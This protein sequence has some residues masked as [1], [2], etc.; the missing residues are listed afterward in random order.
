MFNKKKE[1][2]EEEIKLFESFFST[3]II[4][5]LATFPPSI[6]IDELENEVGLL[7]ED[8]VKKMDIKNKDRE[9]FKRV[10]LRI[11]GNKFKSLNISILI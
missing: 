1:R 8:I 10:C 3:D 5:R 6:E 11:A 7:I 2:L 9:Y 4:G